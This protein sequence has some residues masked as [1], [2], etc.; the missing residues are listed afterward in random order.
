MATTLS[1]KEA[2]VASY[3]GSN[4][5]YKFYLEV[6]LN[7]QST[8]D[9]TSNI[10]I[11]HYAKSNG[12]YS[13]Q[14]FSTPK[15]YLKV[16]DNKTKTTSTKKTTTVAGI[17]TTKTLIGTWTGNVTH[18]SDGTL[19]INITAEYKSNTTSYY[20]VPA[21]NSIS[22]GTIKLPDL[23]TPPAITDVTFVENNSILTG[24]G[25]SADVF[26][27]YLSNK[28]ATI[29]ATA[30][31]NATISKYEIENGTKNFSS[32]SSSVVMDLSD[33]MV[34]SETSTEL[35]VKVT[36]SMGGV[37]SSSIKKTVIPYSIPNLIATSSN[38]KRN[39][40]TTGKAILNLKGTFYNNSVGTKSNSIALSFAYWKTGE[41]ESTTYY[42]IPTSAY[43]ISG[44]VIT[45][46]NWNIAIDGTEISNVDKSSSY[47]FKIKA[48]DAFSKT[49]IIQLNCTSGEYLM[50]KFKDRIDFKKIT[51]KGV[52]VGEQ[53]VLLNTAAY[54]NANQSYTLSEKVSEQA[55]GIVL[56]WCGYSNDKVQDYNYNSFFI[57]K[58]EVE[59]FPGKG[60]N[61]I[62]GGT[63]FN[64]ICSKY[65]YISDD[66]ITG[67]ENN[68]SAGTKN[69]ITYDNTE[70]VLRYVIG[71]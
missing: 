14:Q 34:Y 28:K 3:S 49:S 2:N 69:G 61:M 65:V 62:M 59:L 7:S 56:I 50:A 4:N 37:G 35:I 40:Q 26:V 24:A 55:N 25:V 29:S 71:V 43:T 38:I 30:F 64:P 20:Y 39:G 32:T 31:D 42:T 10:T 17:T 12:A 15:S 21:N 27:P 18:N 5:A 36:D 51:I 1:S 16:Y 46:T 23:H 68:T 9:N 66:K 48:V 67:N 63:T 47:Q 8:D 33:G 45:I 60:H 44:N 41:T 6:K 54:M 11:N 22:T 52:P 58:K 13:Y 19:D 70:F 57:S 53:K